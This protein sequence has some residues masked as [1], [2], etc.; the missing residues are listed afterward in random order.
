MLASF[1]SGIC[2]YGQ[3]ELRTALEKDDRTVYRAPLRCLLPIMVVV[4]SFGSAA[5][6]D[7]KA[8]R[9]AW[10]ANR[11]AEALTQW[12]TAARGGDAHAML[13]L[14]RA[15]VKGLGVP[16]DY[17]EAHKWLN[18][19]AARGNAEAADERDALAAK[20]TSQQVATAQEQARAWRS[21]STVDAPKAVAVPQAAASSPP[22]GRP[23]PRAIR[24]AQE[25]MATLGYKP[26]PS[27]GRCR[28]EDPRF[29]R[30]HRAVHRRAPRP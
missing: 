8:G 23:P 12:Q 30:R 20:M 5:Q 28:S 1:E 7:Y 13:A 29:G 27:D 18:L 10:E 2:P 26:G 9:A 19:A 22:A 3:E 15:Y 21:G 16:Q 11:H 6:S 14:G 25:L 4:V 17:V 24:E